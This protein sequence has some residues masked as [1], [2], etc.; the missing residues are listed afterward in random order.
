MDQ[1]VV[2]SLAKWPGVPAVYGWLALDR[3]GNWLIKN[4]ATQRFDTIGNRALRDFIGRNYLA[5]QRGCWYFQNGP[6]R[7]Y[8]RLAYAPLILRI[9]DAGLAD[10]CGN[11]AGEPRSAWLDQDG[12]LL[13]ETGLGLGLLNDRDLLG[14]S[15][16]LCDVPPVLDLGHTRFP[17]G[18]IRSDELQARFRFVADPQP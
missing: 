16:G 8:V 5:D 3:R 14:V 1:T 17:V 6:Q 10:H 12:S 9:E 7:V 13:V 11:P 2:R 18:A 15:S 4:P